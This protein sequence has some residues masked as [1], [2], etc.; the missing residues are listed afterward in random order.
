MEMD[1]KSLTLKINR[2]VKEFLQTMEIS[3][4]DITLSKIN[5]NFTFL[6]NEIINKNQTIDVNSLIYYNYHEFLIGL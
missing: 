6:E 5:L 2:L 3:K 1:E 4:N